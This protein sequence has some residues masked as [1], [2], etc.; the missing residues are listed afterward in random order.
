MFDPNNNIYDENRK[1]EQNTAPEEPA[2]HTQ[3]EMP[4]DAA[5]EAAE[6]VSLAKP[7]EASPA[8]Y[9]EENTDETA[10]STA[11]P[12]VF[13]EQPEASAEPAEDTAVSPDGTAPDTS[14]NENF[15]RPSVREYH[16]EEQVKKSPKKKKGW[17]RFIAACLIVSV[18]GG[19][20]AGVGYGAMRNYFDSHNTSA[21]SPAVVQKVSAT[22]PCLSAVDI[23]KAVKP[24]VVSISTKFSGQA[25]Y[26]G[27]FTI[28]YEGKGAGSGV[29]FYADA[30][31]IAIVTNNHVVEDADD[32]YVI[33]DSDNSGEEKSVTAKLIG[34]K[35]ES[36]IAVLTIS[37]S[38]LK[39]AGINDVTVATFG[40]SDTLEVGDAVIAIGNA[41]GKGISAT[42]GIISMTEQS[43]KVDGNIL[44][45]LQT[46]AA[47]NGGNSGGALVNSSGQ[48][49]GIN[50]A[51]YNDSM[52]EGMG[53][54][55]PSNEI[56]PIATELLE[57]G[58]QPKPYI[59]VT[60]TSITTDNADLYRLPV[61]AL[62]MEVNEGGPAEA[63][64]LQVG[65]IVTE[66]N[67]KT[68]MD[69]DTLVELVNATEI[70]DT[71]VMHIVR[72]GKEGMDLNLTIQDK[73]NP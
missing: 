54:A 65:D 58:T 31:K 69:M 42:D 60:G 19:A 70:G 56:T 34:S 18:A 11:E 21:K 48:V 20:S 66:Y 72:D 44:N 8:E 25:Q 36:D 16:Y 24:S 1:T 53:Y 14:T 41:M 57:L 3:E 6:K 38:E 67:G 22:S 43:I 30:D 37:Q 23:I 12:S 45:V 33:F 73:N 71:V 49:I 64:G 2:A 55:I 29:V 13:E 32:I 46:S 59:G 5:A 39:K 40:D 7:Q 10:E 68:V 9:A 50:T 61:G 17:G 63:A 51:K 47:I 15:I 28:P 26:I 27:P 52:A 62:I 4:A 35:S